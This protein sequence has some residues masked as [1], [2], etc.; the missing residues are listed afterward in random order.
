[1]P[2]CW[3]CCVAVGSQG[4]HWQLC[5]ILALKRSDALYR[6][7][8]GLPYRCTA[9]RERSDGLYRVIT[10][11]VAKMV[12][13]LGIALLN[14]II[15]GGWVV[16]GW[17]RGGDAVWWRRRG[18]APC[19][20][21]PLLL[22]ELLA[23]PPPLLLLLSCLVGAR[24]GVAL[25]MTSTSTHLPCMRPILHPTC[26]ANI[27]FWALQ[28]KGSFFLFWLIYFFTLTTG[29]GEGGLRARCVCVRV[30]VC[31]FMRSGTHICMVHREAACTC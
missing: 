9:C 18:W 11:L 13:E 1:M 26:A 17:R 2:C 22:P 19:P 25:C 16:L 27:V 29:I 31:V 12:E 4:A 8:S 14:S 23:I 6:C 24:H 5:T 21:M 28:L 15:F 20:A 10:Y 3:Y 7:T 30:Y